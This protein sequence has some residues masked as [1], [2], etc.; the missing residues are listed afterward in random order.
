MS[1]Y[2]AAID[3]LRRWDLR[4]G[5]PA[6]ALVVPHDNPAVE[7]V[8][9]SPDGTT[10]AA[11]S[12]RHTDLWRVGDTAPYLTIDVTAHTAA[13][14]SDRVLA[15]LRSAPGHGDTGLYDTTTGQL[16]GTV[17]GGGSLGHLL[18]SRDGRLVTLSHS[19]QLT[20]WDPAT[21]SALRQFR[22][23]S[24]NVREA[25]MSADGRIV[26]IVLPY[27]IEVYDGET[28]AQLSR[29]APGDIDLRRGQTYRV[30]VRPDGAE[31]AIGQPSGRVVRV[32]PRSGDILGEFRALG[33]N[34]TALAYSVDGTMVAAAG[35]ET[36]RRRTQHAAD[37]RRLGADHR[38]PRGA[39]SD[40]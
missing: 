5:R 4:T 16:I 33:G 14:V 19:G 29:W 22:V 10:L 26:A 17:P 27:G 28:G 34:V 25:A 2:S 39:R 13:F 7:R 20:I 8:L 31:V 32:D 38:R 3:G 15:I 1:L 23:G 9:A 40:H 11:V 30:A 12:L 21:R 35:G 37:R 24:G 36:D 18:A 6:Y